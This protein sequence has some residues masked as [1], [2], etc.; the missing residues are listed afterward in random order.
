MRLAFGIIMVDLGYKFD[1]FNDLER[2][3]VIIKLLKFRALY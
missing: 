3:F 2:G 1:Y